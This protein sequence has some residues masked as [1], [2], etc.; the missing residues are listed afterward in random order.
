M[1]RAKVVFAFLFSLLLGLCLYRLSSAPTRVSALS[2]GSPPSKARAT[3]SRGVCLSEPAW[4][5]GP[6][7]SF[8]GAPGE[9][10]CH[11]C[12]NSHDI[13][14]PS[15]GVTIDLL[16][17]SYVPGGD[18]IAFTVTVFQDGTNGANIDWG[19]ELTVIDANNL[20]AGRLMVTDTMNTQM[21]SG[22]V[23]G[24]TRFYIEQTLDGTFFN[25]GGAPGA[26]WDMAWVPPVTDVG[27]VTFYVAGNAGAGQ[28]RSGTYV[29][30]NNRTVL[31]P[32]GNPVA[33]AL[34]LFGRDG[35]FRGS[36]QHI[37]PPPR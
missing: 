4:S 35:A 11:D 25:L 12:H 15:G 22:E 1:D 27:P 19:F 24:S 20:F 14:D 7:P 9:G 30:T 37:N 21:V 2:M 29:F 23:N 5:S 33:Q 28:G 6:P 3:A 26:T 10:T 36:P 17:D 32:G 16:P 18:P 31:G 13:N 8:T 34:P